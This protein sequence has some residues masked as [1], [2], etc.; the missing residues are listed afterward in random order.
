[1]LLQVN[2]SSMSPTLENGEMVV[3]LQTKRVETGD[4]IGF[5]YGGEVLIKRVIGCGGD[6]I[7]IDQE[8]NVS[9]NGEALAEPYLV[10]KSLGRCELDFPCRVPEGMY[11]VLGDNRAVS[12]DSRIRT[13]GCVE[14]N[15]IIGRVLVRG[16][17]WSRAGIVH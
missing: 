6:L 15:Q 2:G 11:F 5:H 10:E 14:D 17:P 13:L 8:G 3:L 1:M 4:V 7:E 12:I 9:V 16:W